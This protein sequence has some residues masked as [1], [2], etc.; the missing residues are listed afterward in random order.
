MRPHVSPAGATRVFAESSEWGN[1]STPNDNPNDGTG[2]LTY[3]G[4]SSVQSNGSSRSSRS[5]SGES[6]DSSL[7]AIMD[8]LNL[9]DEYN[10][11][12]LA[13]LLVREQ[14]RQQGITG[15]RQRKSSRRKSNGH[16]RSYSNSSSVPS[17]G[18]SLE[19]SEDTSQSSQL[20]LPLEEPR[21]VSGQTSDSYAPD[22]GGGMG[23]VIFK[24]AMPDPPQYYSAQKLTRKSS[25]TSRR[26]SCS[27]VRRISNPMTQGILNT[28]R[29]STSSGGPPLTPKGDIGGT[30][31]NRK[32]GEKKKKSGQFAVYLQSWMCGFPDALNFNDK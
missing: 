2:S 3:S 9:D 4:S 17:L 22:G 20:S 29:A 1:N 15:E 25:D 5:R 16:R 24:P 13:S 7:A 11:T 21:T 32:V 19:Y 26:K 10:D 8:V 28:A 31:G 18:N 12:E 23:S 30:N 27:D 6:T 14:E